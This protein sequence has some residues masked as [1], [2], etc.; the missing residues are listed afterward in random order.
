[1]SEKDQNSIV[2]TIRTSFEDGGVS[3]IS[4]SVRRFPNES[5]F[6]VEVPADEFTAAL[7]VADSA[8]DL[9]SDGF[10][11]VKK[12]PQSEILKQMSAVSSLGD[13]KVTTLIELLNAR[14]RTSEQQPSL[15]I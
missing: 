2:E 10:I 12:A 15:P 9:V 1:M 8:S 14:S 7:E 3:V 11:T 6:I 5:I 13:Q 4:I